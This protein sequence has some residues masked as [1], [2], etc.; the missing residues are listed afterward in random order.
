MCLFRILSIDHRAQR[1]GHQGRL[2]AGP[3]RTEMIKDVFKNHQKVKK[4]NKTQA[5]NLTSVHN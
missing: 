2:Q 5:Q 4:Y 3:A 1:M